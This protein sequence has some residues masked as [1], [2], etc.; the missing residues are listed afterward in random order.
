MPVDMSFLLVLSVKVSSQLMYKMYKSY[1]VEK[2]LTMCVRLVHK[3]FSN[4][5]EY[6]FVL[7][8]FVFIGHTA[9]QC[10]K[11][12]QLKKEVNSYQIQAT[13]VMVGHYARNRTMLFSRN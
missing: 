8:G 7:G 6:I 13:S 9:L 11:G 10:S 1:I 3:A 2:S 4:L 5:P 12:A